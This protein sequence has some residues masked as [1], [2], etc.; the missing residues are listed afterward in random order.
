MPELI[1][2]VFSRMQTYVQDRG[3]RRVFEFVCYS[4]SHLAGSPMARA[5]GPSTLK[6]YTRDLSAA[7]HSLEMLW[8]DSH[9]ARQVRHDPQ[10]L[11]AFE[12]YHAR[13]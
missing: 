12:F 11:P 2:S 7:G 5:S 1:R 13:S 3:I 8:H 4:R 10:S 9:R 6:G